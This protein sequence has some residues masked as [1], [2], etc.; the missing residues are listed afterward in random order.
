MGIYDIRSIFP[1]FEPH[2]EQFTQPADYHITGQLI[3]DFKTSASPTPHLKESIPKFYSSFCN[4]P[5]VPKHAE[6]F[7]FKRVSERT[8]ELKWCI[9]E[10]AE[11]APRGE[12]EKTTISTNRTPPFR[13]TRTYGST[14][15]MMARGSSSLD[16]IFR[17]IGRT[18]TVTAL[19]LRSSRIYLSPRHGSIFP[20]LS[21][22]RS[23]IMAR[24]RTTEAIFTVGSV[25]PTHLRD[26]AA[27]VQNERRP[28]ATMVYN[29]PVGKV[30]TEL[31]V[32]IF[33][34]A[35]Q[36]DPETDLF[37]LAVDCHRLT[38]AVGYRLVDVWL[39]TVEVFKLISRERRSGAQC[40]R[41]AGL[42][43]GLLAPLPS[44]RGAQLIFFTRNWSQLNGPI[45]MSSPRSPPSSF[46]QNTHSVISPRCVRACR[47]LHAVEPSTLVHPRARIEPHYK[48]TMAHSTTILIPDACPE[49]CADCLDTRYINHPRI[50]HPPSTHPA[51]TALALNGC[52]NCITDEFLWAFTYRERSAPQLAPQLQ[53]LR[54]RNIDGRRF[55]D[56]VFE[57]AIG[58]G[59]GKTTRLHQMSR[60]CG[61]CWL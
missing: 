27:Q 59:V 9:D 16:G 22:S 40:V 8:K 37:F 33:L 6:W 51:L 26:L 61:A 31:L 38:E 13:K 53:E 44:N 36:S 14:E 11:Q 55:G 48:R 25:R 60:G 10:G 1:L 35:I 34:L 12:Q 56:D 5:R 17:P 15:P 24:I 19:S 41:T 29:S 18:I 47:T 42:V 54:L 28:W 49:C 57:A 3:A 21:N 50:A 32:E 7:L 39:R 43:L 2:T 4:H 52:P 23:A 20:G 30:P 58:R 46:A 45:P